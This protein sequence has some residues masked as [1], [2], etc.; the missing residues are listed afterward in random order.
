MI[1]YDEERAMVYQWPAAVEGPTG[2]RRWRR[3]RPFWGGLFMIISGLLILG[4][5]NLDLGNI[6]IHLG[7]TGFLSYVIPA[8][9]ILCG[10]LI[11]VT[12]EQRFFYSI[13]GII[14]AIYSLISVNLGGF[15]VGMLFGLIGG[16]LAFAW[17]PRKHG[18]IAVPA[19]RSG[20]PDDALDTTAA[21]TTTTEFGAGEFGS[22]DEAE[23]EGKQGARFRGPRH[24]ADDAPVTTDE[25]DSRLRTPG[26][27]AGAFAL[28]AL[29]GGSRARRRTESAGRIG[30]RLYAPDDR[31]DEGARPAPGESSSCG[32]RLR[33]RSARGR[34]HGGD[35]HRPDRRSGDRC[36]HAGHRRYA[37]RRPEQL[38]RS[39]AD[40]HPERDADRG[41]DHCA[42]EPG[43]V[44]DRDAQAEAADVALPQRVA[45]VRA[46]PHVRRRYA[47]PLR[48]LPD[49]REEPRR[50]AGPALRGRESGHDDGEQAD[51]ERPDVR[52]QRRPA[53]EVGDAHRDGVLDGL[54]HVDAVRA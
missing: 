31:A 36:H 15:F 6:Q 28:I 4:S 33:R 14:A 38:A 40:R 43:A 48:L 11:W 53:D 19:Q 29:V 3:N 20:D 30:R 23:S 17:V 7:V 37:G 39:D 25:H 12:P 50:R 35:R 32:C 16:C 13:I 26:F 8:V 42:A 27:I 41:S 1:P 46:D 24:A 18:D 22:G 21:D 49:H 5:G 54:V 47:V 51:H 44:A 10:A 34:T 52:R 9:L 45:D 2:F